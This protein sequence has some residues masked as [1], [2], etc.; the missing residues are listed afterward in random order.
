M[1]DLKDQLSDNVNN[2]L[3]KAILE[4]NFTNLGKATP[5]RILHKVADGML[6]YIFP[7]IFRWTE[8]ILGELFLLVLNAKEIILSDTTEKNT[9]AELVG[10]L[11]SQDVNGKEQ[12]M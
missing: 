7:L 5:A 1:W 9:S 4:A 12:R 10:F 11:S 6:W 8:S 2:K 3:L